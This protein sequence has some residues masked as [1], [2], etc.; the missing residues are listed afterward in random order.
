MARVSTQSQ[1]YDPND[2]DGNG[3]KGDQRVTVNVPAPV[4]NVTNSSAAQKLSNDKPKISALSTL[5]KTGLAKYRDTKLTNI[6]TIYKQLDA[7]LLKS[8]G[9]RSGQLNAS[10]LDNDKAEA[11]ASFMNLSNRARE[12]ADILGQSALQGAGESDTLRAQMMSIRNWQSNQSDVNRSF[13]DTQRGINSSIVDLN[14]DTRSARIGAAQ[15]MLNDKE[16]V[17][18]NF[19]DRKTD[20]YTQMGNIEGDPYSDA[21]KKNSSAY[22]NMATTAS[23]AW[24]NPGI[25]SSITGWKGDVQA[26]EQRLN[27][28]ALGNATQLVAP[29]KPEGATLR[30]WD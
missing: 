27:N 10:K 29:K 6:D 17:W 15:N 3:I 19:Y 28:S 5:I 12:H 18:D 30:K 20:A 13:Y 7:D 16:Q 4:V 9:E 1:A 21:Y 25:S 23:Q 22:A 24:S 26:T 11:G 8:Y 14:A 2:P